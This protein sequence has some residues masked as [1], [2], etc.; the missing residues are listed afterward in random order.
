M[1]LNLYS[2]KNEHN[3]DWQ[4]SVLSQ[5][6]INLRYNM[7][8]EKNTFTSTLLKVTLYLLKITLVSTSPLGPMGANKV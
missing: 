3:T 4:Y 7:L 6:S 2:T 8:G 5:L 1:V